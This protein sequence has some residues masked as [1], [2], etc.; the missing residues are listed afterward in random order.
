MIGTS[1]VLH[2]LLAFEDISHR[3]RAWV[4]FQA[5]EEWHKVR[6]ESE[7]DGPIFARI[8]NEMWRPTNYSPL[9]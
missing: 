8:R 4:P 1:N 7:Q 5:D 9:R 3:E 2:Y 6:A